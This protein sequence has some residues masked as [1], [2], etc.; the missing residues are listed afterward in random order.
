[1]ISIQTHDFSI[2][3]EYQQLIKDAPKIGAIVTFTGLVREFTDN[4]HVDLFLEHYPEMTEKVLAD[5]IVQA[6]QRWPILSARI[7][8]RIG[9]LPL[10]DQIVFVGVNS[11]HRGDAFAACEFIMDFLKTDAPF[12]KKE[13]TQD[14]EHWV[15]AKQTDSQ[16]KKRWQ[17]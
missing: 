17:T 3:Q 5:I 4:K 11:P 9:H 8:H 14:S 13:I 2:E 10:G 15:E 1:M 16:A 7:I 6:Q 12:W